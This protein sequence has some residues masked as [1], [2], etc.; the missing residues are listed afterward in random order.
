MKEPY[1][2]GVA[3][4]TGPE[5]CVA[6]REDRCEALTGV[7][8]GRVLSR[9]NLFDFGVPT[10]FLRAEGHTGQVATRDLLRTPRGPRPHARMETL[11]AEAGRSRV[12]PGPEDGQVRGVNPKGARR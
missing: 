8:A 3:S 9:E 6:V 12:R 1:G 4:H 5:S 10:P 7:H 11:H 2:E